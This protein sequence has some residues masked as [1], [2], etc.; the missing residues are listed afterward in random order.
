MQCVAACNVG[1]GWGCGVIPSALIARTLALSGVLVF[2]G[3]CSSL[4]V[5]RLTTEIQGVWCAQKSSYTLHDFDLQSRRLSLESNG[6]YTLTVTA[7]RGQRSAH[8]PPAPSNFTVMLKGTWRT[9]GDYLLM[10]EGPTPRSQESK[11]QSNVVEIQGN[12]LSLQ[13]TSS[14]AKISYFKGECDMRQPS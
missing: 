1:A 4:P 10:K 6:S 9:D 12:E 5:Q 11:E 8:N 2:C 14:A 13:P 3:G 7:I